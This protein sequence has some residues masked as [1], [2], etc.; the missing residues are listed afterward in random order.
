MVPYS[1]IESVTV[2]SSRISYDAM[3]PEFENFLTARGVTQMKFKEGSLSDQ[4][5]LIQIYE[6]KKNTAP[7]KY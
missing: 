3:D 7:G 2:A 4:T 6:S 5:V 1:N